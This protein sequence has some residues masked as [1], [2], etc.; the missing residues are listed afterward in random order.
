MM[1][2]ANIFETSANFYNTAT[3]MIAIFIFGAV[4]TQNLP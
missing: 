4:R 3:Q 1:E 2:A